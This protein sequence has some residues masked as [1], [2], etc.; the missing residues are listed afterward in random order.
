LDHVKVGA[1]CN[2][3]NMRRVLIPP[4]VPVGL[5][6]LFGVDGQLPV[7]IHSHQEETRI[8]LNG[9]EQVHAAKS[10]STHIYEIRVVSEA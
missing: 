10:A 8:R 2:R 6:D 3:V 1:V 9:H 5:N 7:G 4:L